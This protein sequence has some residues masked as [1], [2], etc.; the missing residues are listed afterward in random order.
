[1][2][3]G[4]RVRISFGCPLWCGLDTKPGYHS[5]QERPPGSCTRQGRRGSGEAP[6]KHPVAQRYSMHELGWRNW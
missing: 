4:M 3:L 5:C 6:L 2:P 1:M